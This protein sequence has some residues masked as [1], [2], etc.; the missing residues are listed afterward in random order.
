MEE[1]IKFLDS[2]IP[3]DEEEKELMRNLL[4]VRHFRKRE[5]IQREG[6]IAKKFYFNAK[7]F[8]R[9]FY[10]AKGEEKTAFFY[11]K[12][13]FVSDFESYVHETPTKVNFQ[14]MEDTILV[15]ITKDIANQWLKASQ[16]MEALAID[17]MEMEMI[18]HQKLIRSILTETPEE[19]YFKLMDESPEIIEKVPSRHIA[20]YLGVAP[21]SL[22]R[23]K[24][25]H[26]D[27]ILTNVNV[28]KNSDN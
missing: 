5:I 22:S 25:R 11:P 3:L 1:L 8:V 19:R 12:N 2:I 27:R 14:A 15:E 17:L 6:D 26:F 9:L 20:S 21:E 24:K 13:N 7:G 23:I 10:L 18:L 4:R 16:K 28:L